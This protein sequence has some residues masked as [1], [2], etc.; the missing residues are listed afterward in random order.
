MKRETGS[1][2]WKS[3]RS[4]SVMSATP[5]IGLVMEKIRQIVSS[6]TGT[7]RAASAM[8]IEVKYASCPWRA[9]ATWQPAIL[10]WST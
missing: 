1:P 5:A 6:A 4:Y 9:T 8:P 2:S 10:P 3:P 7:S